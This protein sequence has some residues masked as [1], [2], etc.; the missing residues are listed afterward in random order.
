LFFSPGYNSPLVCIAPFIFTIHDLNHIDCPENSSPIKRLYYASILKR[1]CRRAARILTVSEFSR[2]RILAWSGVS[3][4]KVVNV[5]CGVDPE[6]NPHAAPYEL[7]FPYLLCVSNRRR[8]KNEFRQIEAFAKSGLSKQIKL[9]F[10][11]NPTTEIVDCIE[12]NHVTQSIH[13]VGHV[14][15]AQLPSL[16][17]SAMALMFVSLYEGFGLP[18][19]EAM[20]CG[21]PVVT[22]NTSSLPEIAG[23]AALLVDPTSVEQIAA[24][25]YR[26]TSDDSLR[27]RLKTRG[28]ERAAGFPWKITEDK[29]HECVVDITR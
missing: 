26:I 3:P 29:V 6:Y 27:E 23:D 22:A 17:G 21:T 25:I 5:R 19:L 15:D 1:A 14:L 4:E 9:V 28:L 24:A 12:R 11:G 20:A 16:Y 18:V 2:E 13:F 7:P 8:H 10:T